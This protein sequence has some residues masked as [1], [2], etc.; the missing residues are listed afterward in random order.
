MANAMQFFSLYKALRAEDTK[1]DTELDAIRLQKARVDLA[2]ATVGLDQKLKD[3]KMQ[4]ASFQFSQQTGA[5][6]FFQS[7]VT[8]WRKMQEENLALSLGGVPGSNNTWTFDEGEGKGEIFKQAQQVLRQREMNAVLAIQSN[9]EQLVQKGINGAQLQRYMQQELARYGADLSTFDS[10]RLVGM[11]AKNSLQKN[12]NISIKQLD[13]QA[14]SKSIDA[15]IADQGVDLDLGRV[16]AIEMD[17]SEYEGIVDTLRKQYETYGNGGLKAE[18]R[19]IISQNLDGTESEKSSF[20]QHVKNAA[21]QARNVSDNALMQRFGAQN[22]ILQNK[23]SQQIATGLMRDYGLNGVLRPTDPKFDEHWQT[24]SNVYQNGLKRLVG[25]YKDNEVFSRYSDMSLNDMLQNLSS[26]NLDDEERKNMN[27]VFDSILLRGLQSQYSERTDIPLT[28][29][30]R[31]VLKPVLDDFKR[32]LFKGN[33]SANVRGMELF[34]KAVGANLQLKDSF[35]D[36]EAYIKEAKGDSSSSNNGLMSSITGMTDQPVEKFQN[37]TVINARRELAMDLGDLYRGNG[38]INVS[39]GS[40]SFT[41]SGNPVANRIFRDAS[42]RPNTT[43]EGHQTY[44]PQFKT[45]YDVDVWKRYESAL[46]DIS[47]IKTSKDPLGQNFRA[48]METLNNAMDFADEVRYSEPELAYSIYKRVNN[49]T[50]GDTSVKMA[51][52]AKKYTETHRNLFEANVVNADAVI[53]DNA[54]PRLNPNADIKKLFKFQNQADR[55]QGMIAHGALGLEYN[56]G[57]RTGSVD[58]SYLD[59][60]AIAQRLTD[61]YM[62]NQEIENN[63]NIFL[64]MANQN[65]INDLA[66]FVENTKSFG[67]LFESKRFARMQDDYQ[68]KHIAEFELN[69]EDLIGSEFNYASEFLQQLRKKPTQLYTS[70]VTSGLSYDDLTDFDDFLQ[71]PSFRKDEIGIRPVAQF[72]FNSIQ[73]TKENAQQIAG[74]LEHF[75]KTRYKDVS[76]KRIKTIVKKHALNNSHY[77]RVQIW[78]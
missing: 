24:M 71:Q 22:G 72:N 70:I 32:K 78:N 45:G 74:T 39:D 29:R 49:V 1:K 9:M 48:N 68:R 50:L 44:I 60:G 20:S 36:V 51:V 18:V 42:I 54:T 66:Q 57:T 62:A 53:K 26:P 14:F 31:T 67:G 11:L 58:N 64:E 15:I 76:I 34:K 40:Y 30:S 38:M 16:V 23:I 75:V 13:D 47:G 6:K 77:V 25:D 28:E 3:Q 10:E 69:T 21:I 19:K 35:D 43:I 5:L 37:Q 52:M 17:R 61:N 4:E 56:Q 2:S 73:A 27:Y 65:D 63:L 7:N 8:D 59:P 12:G 55:E 33:T 46:K 41:M